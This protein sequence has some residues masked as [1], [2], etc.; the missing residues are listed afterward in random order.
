MFRVFLVFFG[1]YHERRIRLG[2]FEL[3][4][5]GEM[6]SGSISNDMRVSV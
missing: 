5:V 3:C 1:A 4:G 2:G 6:V